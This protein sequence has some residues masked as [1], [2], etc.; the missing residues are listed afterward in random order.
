MYEKGCSLKQKDFIQER[1]PDQMTNKAPE[2][3]FS[4]LNHRMEKAVAEYT[5]LTYDLEG[6]LK[7]LSGD[8]VPFDDEGKDN[9]RLLCHLSEYDQNINLLNRN[10]KRIT[11]LI[12]ALS[13][14]A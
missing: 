5:N 3:V 11:T 8:G 12:N 13:K 9:D 7:R 4:E 14:I 6:L 10:N 1:F 2:N